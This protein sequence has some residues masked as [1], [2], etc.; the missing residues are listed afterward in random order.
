MVEAFNKSS[1]A[2][3][4]NNFPQNLASSQHTPQL[5][6]STNNSTCIKRIPPPQGREIIKLVIEVCRHGERMPKDEYNLSLNP[7]DN[8]TS[9][10]ELTKVGYEN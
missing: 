2:G 10:H 4:R 5:I 8:S 9:P 6:S 3:N 1:Q 7:I